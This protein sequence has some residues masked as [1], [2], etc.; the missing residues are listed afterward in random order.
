[1]ADSPRLNSP[2]DTADKTAEEDRAFADKTVIGASELRSFMVRKDLPALIR[3]TVLLMVHLCTGFGVVMALNTGWL[4]PA[5]FVHGFLLVHLFSLQHECA[6]M[7]AFKTRRFNDWAAWYCGVVINLGPRY[8]QHE[9]TQHHTY[10]QHGSKDPQRVPL[11]QSLPGYLLYLSALPYW[12]SQFKALFIHAA[13]TIPESEEAFLPPSI[14]GD[15]VREARII[16]GIYALV[17]VASLAF[18]WLWPLYLW[19][20]PLLLAEPC[21]RFIRMTEHVG[22]PATGDLTKNT[23]TN[24]VPWPF[25]MVCWNMNYHAEHH[26]A[27]S[28]PFHAL[29]A[30]HARI[31]AALPQTA[32]YFAA[33][34]QIR[35][36]MPAATDP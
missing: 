29:P 1:M 26:F 23:R 13:G 19:I 20:G 22:M 32:G 4:L 31:G 35:D 10:T 17:L 33:H 3:T 15:V 16:C 11:P 30:L 6:H 18:G 28:V 2:C 25:Q 7:T 24:H 5:M 34:R 12:Y 27:P 36:A 8:F 14:R 21:M 9:H